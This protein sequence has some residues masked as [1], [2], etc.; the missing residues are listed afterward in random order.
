MLWEC[1]AAI[2]DYT[3]Q[4]MQRLLLECVYHQNNL[5]VRSQPRQLPVNQSHH[6]GINRQRVFSRQIRQIVSVQLA[7]I[8]LRTSDLLQHPTSPYHRAAN[9]KNTEPQEEP[10]KLR[11]RKI[12]N[13]RHDVR[14]AT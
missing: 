8:R 10:Q 14:G 9:Y 2:D 12:K 5:S 6:R 3:L 4:R 11:P 7:R 1:S 13:V